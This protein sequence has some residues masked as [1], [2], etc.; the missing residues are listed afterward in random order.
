MQISMEVLSLTAPRTDSG[1]SVRDRTKTSS[2]IESVFSK[3]LDETRTVYFPPILTEGNP[4]KIATEEDTIRDTRQKPIKDEIPGTLLAVGVAGNQNMVVFILEGDKESAAIP[5]IDAGAAVNAEETL[6]VSNGTIYDGEAQGTPAANDEHELFTE[7]MPE[8]E[9]AG[10]ELATYSASGP[11]AKADTE[12]KTETAKSETVGHIDNSAG[13]ATA[14]TPI[15][16]TSDKTETG[17]NLYNSTGYTENGAL[18]PL[19]NGN[20]TAPA[21]EHRGK[22]YSDTAQAVRN[23]ADEMN[24][25]ENSAT[26]PLAD[27]IKPERFQAEQQMKQAPHASPVEKKNLFNEM[28]SRIEMMQTSEKSGMTIQLK[29]EFLGKVALEIALDA[30]G[31]HVKINAEDGSVRSMINGQMAALIESLE[32]KGI[33]VAEVEVTYTGVN[34]GAF[35]DSRE[36]QAQQDRPRRTLHELE[37]VDGAEFYAVLPFSLPEDYLDEIVSSVE[38]SA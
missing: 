5:E 16:R 26:V 12:T 35:K 13:D 11:Q 2:S 1:A 38:Y 31:L 19:E 7:D 37:P 36:N 24:E 33:A 4:G 34:N 8:T 32:N 18:S 6:P 22:T 30:T 9:T 10:A 17:E 25:N 29:P 14:R 21:K 15:V 3:I 20:D 23:K 28:V 27:G